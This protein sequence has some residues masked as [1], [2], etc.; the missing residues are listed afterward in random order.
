VL[1][2][3]KSTGALVSSL[4]ASVF[5]TNV[6]TADQY[7]AIVIPGR[8]FKKS[9]EERGYA[10]SVLSRA[11]GASGTPTSALVPW[12]SCGAYM[13]ATLGVA[14]FSY[15]P[16]AVFNIASPLIVILLAILGLRMPK[17]AT[18]SKSGKDTT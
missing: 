11:V 10:P 2:A 12:N 4:V 18:S 7:I 9:F 1:R 15:A 13:A 16:Y 8:M 6:V 5:A 17:T 3:A 14:T